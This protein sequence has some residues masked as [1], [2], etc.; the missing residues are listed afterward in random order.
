MAKTPAFPISFPEPGRFAP[1]LL[2]PASF[3]RVEWGEW[4]EIR[5]VRRDG[6]WY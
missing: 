1:T 5:W 3:Q 2:D 6:F 4:E